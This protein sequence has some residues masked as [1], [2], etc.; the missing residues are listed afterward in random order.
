MANLVLYTCRS[1][2]IQKKQEAGEDRLRTRG[3]RRSK[4]TITLY[5]RRP[6]FPYPLSR[7]NEYI[8][9]DIIN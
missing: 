9:L 1:L 5:Y 2:G 7:N 8:Y 4:S 3:F 6:G